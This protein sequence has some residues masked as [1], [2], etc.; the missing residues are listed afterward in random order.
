VNDNDPVAALA[1]DLFEAVA[2][3]VA[4]RPTEMVVE[5]FMHVT[6]AVLSGC[7]ENGARRQ[8]LEAG[9]TILRRYADAEMPRRGKRR[10]FDA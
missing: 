1:S 5:A 7:A 2:P 4:Q 6:Q 10:R 3:L 9:A 8:V